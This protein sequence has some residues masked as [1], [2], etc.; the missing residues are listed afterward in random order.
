MTDVAARPTHWLDPAC[1]MMVDPLT[2]KGGTTRHEG[3]DYAFCNTRCRGRFLADPVAVLAEPATDPVCG[4]PV[5]RAGARFI[6]ADGVRSYFHAEACEEAF[7]AD[8]ARFLE[9]E[10]PPLPDADESAGR[11]KNSVSGSCS[12]L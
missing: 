4:A 2:A 3:V 11:V 6:D 12:R 7:R 1:N 8:P 5:L 9:T 10:P